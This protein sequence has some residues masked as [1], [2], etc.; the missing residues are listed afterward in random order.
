MDSLATQ[1]GDTSKNRGIKEE[2]WFVVRNA[3]M[4]SVLVELGFVSNPA[5]AALLADPAYLQ[6]CA[7]GIYNGLVSFIS[8]FEGSRGFTQGR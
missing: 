1:I 5:E 7:L 4:P 8:Y 2:A 6:R 3:R